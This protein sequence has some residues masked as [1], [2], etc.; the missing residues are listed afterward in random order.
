VLGGGWRRG[1]RRLRVASPDQD[2]IV[3]IPGQPLGIEEFV[4]EGR[5]GIV[6]QGELHFERPIR[7]TAPLAQERNDLIH[8]RDKVHPIPSLPYALPVYTGATPS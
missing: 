7:H 5:Q 4:L 8:H 1:W 2:A 3:L 6:V